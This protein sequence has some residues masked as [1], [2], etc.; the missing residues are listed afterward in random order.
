MI[1]NK[2]DLFFIKKVPLSYLAIMNYTL[3]CFYY[4]FIII[5][6]FSFDNKYPLNYTYQML[7]CLK[8]HLFWSITKENPIKK[9]ETTG[10]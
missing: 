2:I 5:H 4:N 9:K 7:K 8:I 3:L 6:A 1:L 10:W